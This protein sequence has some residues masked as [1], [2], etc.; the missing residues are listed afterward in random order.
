MR[1]KPL[2]SPPASLATVRAAQA[3]VPLVA[4]PEDDCCAR[5]QRDLGLAA[6]DTAATWLD[7]L[8]ALGLVEKGAT[9]FVRSR[10]EPDRDALAASFLES[11]Y[12]AREVRSELIAAAAPLDART[13]A[14]RTESLVSP[15]E[16]QRDGSDWPAVWAAR[17]RDLLE[18]LALLGVAE[19]SADGY[20]VTD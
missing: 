10:S 16:R 3:A 14:R 8:R 7:F 5:L 17:T 18:W 9:G 6:R 13:V 11:V 20:T 12:A 1:R 15:W 19:E 4:R 2:P